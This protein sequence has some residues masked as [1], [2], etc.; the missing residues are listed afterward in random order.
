MGGDPVGTGLVASLARP[1]GNV[2][3]VSGLIGGGFV[4][5]WMELLKQAAPRITR[6]WVLRDSRNP[7]NERFLPDL[8]AAAQAL[9][10]KLQTR[11]VSSWT[12]EGSCRTVIAS[13][14][15]GGAPPRTSIRFL[16]A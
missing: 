7:F 14:I 4:A 6:V 15:S 12:P 9:G 11:A 3:G 10:L 1:G 16:R 2:T 5:K 13:P 8:Q